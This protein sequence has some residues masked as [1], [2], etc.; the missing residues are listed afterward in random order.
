[1]LAFAVCAAAIVFA[2]DLL[3]VRGVAVP[4]LYIV[5]IGLAHASGR[6]AAVWLLAAVCLLMTCLGWW[7]SAADPAGNNAL[8]NRGLALAAIAMAAFFSDRMRWLVDLQAQTVRGKQ[9]LIGELES[10]REKLREAEQRYRLTIDS[11]LDAV[12]TIDDQGVV[13]SWNCQAERTFGWM[14]DEAIGRSLETLIIPSQFREDH[15]RGLQRMRSGGPA[16][17]LNQRLELS[18]LHRDGSEF[19]IELSIARLESGSHDQFSGFIRD[20]TSHRRMLAALRDRERTITNLLDSTAEGIYGLDLAGHCTF[21]NAACARLLGYDSAADLLGASMHHLIHHSQA[22]GTPIPP[23][24]C[25]IYQAFR[26]GHEVHIDDEVFWRKDGTPFDAEYWS[27]PVA[28]DDDIEGCVVTFLDI[29]DRKELERRQREWQ[30]ELESRVAQRSAELVHARDR[31]EL[32]LTGANI[33]LW[34][35]N[36]QTNEVYYSATYKLQLGYSADLQWNHFNDWESRLHPED[37]ERS[38]AY[39]HDYFA[40]RIDA[41]R[42]TFRMRCSDGSYRWILSQG[43]AFFDADGNP[44]RVIGVHVDITERIETQQELERL[45][46]ALA[47]ANEALQQ[48]NLDLQHFASLASH[49]LQAPLRAISG[50]SQFLKNEYEGQLDETA[51]GYINRIV[52]GVQRMNQLIRDLLEFSRVDS[53]AMPPQRVDLNDTCDDAVALLQA[54]IKDSEGRVTRDNLPQVSG[55][56][57]QL[58]RVLQNLIGNA[59]KYCRERLPEIHVSA[60]QQPDQWTITVQDNGIGIPAEDRERVFEIFRRLHRSEEFPGTGIGLAICRRIIQRHGGRIWIEPTED[61]GTKIRF[62]LPNTPPE[63]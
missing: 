25:H 29:T 41:F 27:F 13:T 1:M 46:T 15:R 49:D 5:A 47:A 57:A 16:R 37:R 60:V 28:R 7:L 32:A 14:A 22:D 44:T 30:N 9:Q 53:Q 23:E 42:P 17:A 34:D 20:M 45:N 36:A 56:P 50:F 6:R 39:V 52:G 4:V 33:G 3:L 31:L 48:S 2:T 18:A 62:T 43:R 24:E 54:A 61:H 63:Q 51:D 11:A 59:L 19:P 35:W 12:I 58:S 8:V 10:Q 40:G 21:A 26:Q 38:V 55:D